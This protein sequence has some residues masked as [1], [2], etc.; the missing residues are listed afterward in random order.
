VNL[1]LLINPLPLFVEIGP[2][3]LKAR[4]GQD[5]IQLSLERGPDGRITAPAKAQTVLALKNFLKLKS[6]LP[7]PRAWCAIGSRGVSLRRLSLPGGSKEEF[8][9]RLLLQIEAEFP[10]PPDELAWGSQLV[11]HSERANGSTRQDLLVAAVKK[12]LIADYHEILHACGTEPSFTLAAMARWNY[13]GQPEN[14]FALLEVGPRQS[15]L[16]IFEQAVPVASRILFW[17]GKNAA[18]PANADMETLAKSLPS[19]PPGTRFFVSGNGITK[20]FNERLAGALGNGCKC[21]RLDVPNGD[22]AAISGLEQMAVRGSTPPL[23]IRLEHKN[24]HAAAT[25]TALDWKTWG[26]RVGVLAGAL[27]LLPYA[28]ALLLKPHLEKKVAAFRTEAERLTVIDREL[29]FLRDLKLSQPPYLDVLYVFSKSVPPGTRFDALSLNSH[30][31]ISLRCAFHDGQQV[32]DFR[33]KIIAS[34]FFTNVVVEEQVPTPDRQKVNVRI[35]ALEK[36]AAQLQLASA[37]LVAEET[38]RDAKTAK[39]VAPPAPPPGAPPIKKDL[40]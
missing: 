7:R 26:T 8:H 18:N 36:S 4:H 17:D 22:S 12:E 40:P 39:S 35:S 25:F 11:G 5:D 9:E 16:T 28:E 14:S 32:A 33:N 31:E 27:L 15:E 20:D 24:G 34:G 2:D 37:R 21:E 30:G 23:V 19:C 10:L 3:W 29:D 38:A 13:C 1:A 6:W